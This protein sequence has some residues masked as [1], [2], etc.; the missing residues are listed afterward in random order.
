[1]KRSPA[2]RDAV[3]ARKRVTPKMASRS[4]RQDNPPRP[5]SNR[6]WTKQRRILKRRRRG[7]TLSTSNMCAN[8]LSNLSMTNTNLANGAETKLECL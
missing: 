7:L 8:A 5:H 3:V 1:M 6:R 2:G 4:P